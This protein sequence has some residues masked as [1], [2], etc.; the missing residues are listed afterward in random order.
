[1]EIVEDFTT[2]TKPKNT[3]FELAEAKATKAIQE[4]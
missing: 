3:N 4:T 1:M 2:T